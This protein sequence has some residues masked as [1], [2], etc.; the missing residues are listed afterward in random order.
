MTFGV[1]GP[2]TDGVSSLWT[3]LSLHS[4]LCTGVFYSHMFVVFISMP[5]TYKWKTERACY[6]Q[7]YL[8]GAL[9]A[10]HNG[11]SVRHSSVQHG[12]SEK[13]YSEV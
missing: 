7:D 1:K 8:Q 13:N 2:S 6:I 12:R 9:E 5:R 10:V 3:K 11:M 4:I